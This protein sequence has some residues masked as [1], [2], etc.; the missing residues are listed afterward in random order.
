MT[1]KRRRVLRGAAWIAASA[2]I[3]TGLLLA[4]GSAQAA[5]VSLTEN[6]LPGH[7]RLLSDPDPSSLLALSP[8]AP[9]QWQ[10]KAD[11]DDTYSP[12]TIQFQ[13]DGELAARPDGLW[14]QVKACDVEWQNFPAAPRCASAVT[15]L[16]SRPADSPTL[17]PGGISGP[18]APSFTVGPMWHS[19]GKFLLVTM[20]LPDTA[21]AR[22]DNSLMGLTAT[23]GV[24]L[25]VIGDQV[26]PPV[27][28][29]TGLAYTGSDALGTMLFGIGVLG[30]G[31][32]VRS[33]TRRSA[34]RHVRGAQSS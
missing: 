10:I 29:P 7:L 26:P 32:L 33:R 13:R 4:S 2:A 9:V 1:S 27:T 28:Q 16:T 15:V 6:G 19:V 14:L 21:E 22:A 8:G 18:L 34:S 11:L 20:S 3:A 30:L 23:L 31:V 17:G 24:G 5:W 12:L 25:T